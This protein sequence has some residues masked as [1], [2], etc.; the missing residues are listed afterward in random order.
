MKVSVCV[1]TPKTP[2]L[3]ENCYQ[4]TSIVDGETLQQGVL[5]SKLIKCKPG[6]S[7]NRKTIVEPPNNKLFTDRELKAAITQQ[8][9]T[10]SLEDTIHP[11]DK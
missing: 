2:R 9:N 11:V 5:H 1:H 6:K 7:R 3:I 8:K 10:A 4:A